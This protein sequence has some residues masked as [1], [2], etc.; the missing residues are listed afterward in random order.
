M[1]TFPH[2][3]RVL[4]TAT[5]EGD[6]VL[7]GTGL[8]NITSQPPAEF[9]GPGDRWSPESLLMAAI[10][11][12]FTLSFRA[13]AAASKIPFTQLDVNVEGV[14]NKVARKMLFTEVQIT[15]SLQVPQGVD[16]GRAERLLTM[17]EQACLVTNSL[18]VECHL[19][20]TV[21]IV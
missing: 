4:A 21:K 15:A 12:C 3:Y 2:N 6:V 17:A 14:L 18:R 16:A 7:S 20:S 19:E 9:D 11:D 8:P 13:I 1:N 5:T 10:A